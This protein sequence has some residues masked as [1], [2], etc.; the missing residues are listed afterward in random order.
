M[1]ASAHRLQKTGDNDR[2]RACSGDYV[3]LSVSM[4]LEENETITDVAWLFKVSA[5]PIDIHTD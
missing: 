4:E 1:L 5:V 3:T 2:V